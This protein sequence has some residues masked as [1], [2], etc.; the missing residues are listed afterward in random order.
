M[1]A[2]K[3]SDINCPIDLFSEQEEAIERLTQAINEAPSTEEKGARAQELLDA[4]NVLLDCEHYDETN[5]NCQ[6]CREI[7]ELR[8]KTAKLVIKASQLG[9]LSSKDETRGRS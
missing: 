2:R 9:E 4:V 7:A 8:R 1:S 6:L 5:K 3:Q